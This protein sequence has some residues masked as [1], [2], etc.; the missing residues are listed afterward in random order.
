MGPVPQPRSGWTTA[1]LMV[2]SF[3]FFFFPLR[4][5]VCRRVKASD[6]LADA[7]H[8]CSAWQEHRVWL[9]LGPSLPRALSFPGRPER[10]H[11]A[12]QMLRVSLAT[13]TNGRRWRHPRSFLSPDEPL[14]GRVRPVGTGCG[15][16]RNNNSSSS[17]GVY[18]PSEGTE[19]KKKQV[20]SLICFS[21][22]EDSHP[23]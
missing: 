5:A 3:P 19:K 21:N 14:Q 15:Y 8:S 18:R 12:W 2:A 7:G 11:G 13:R 17:S 22:V 9:R 16:V 1:P 20:K 4:S 23:G 10:P 6:A